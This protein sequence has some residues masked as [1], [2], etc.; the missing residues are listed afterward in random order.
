MQETDQ[1]PFD[2]ESIYQL[3]L[4]VRNTAEQDSDDRESPVGAMI[5]MLNKIGQPIGN[6]VT[7]ANKFPPE[8]LQQAQY[9]PTM[10]QRPRKYD[11][12][13]HAE[14]RLL[15]IAGMSVASTI[16]YKFAEQSIM[17]TTHKPCSNCARVIGQFVTAMRMNY[18]IVD[19]DSH[20]RYMDAV[21]AVDPERH[22]RAFKD[23]EKAQKILSSDFGVRYIEWSEKQHFPAR[24]AVNG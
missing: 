11:Y 4:T 1:R 15:L 12:V 13:I 5:V 3:I 14:E 16:D 20:V 19:S 9:D 2:N 6:P 23:R 18:L 21:K 10:L 7:S 24:E 8:I 22:E 17:L